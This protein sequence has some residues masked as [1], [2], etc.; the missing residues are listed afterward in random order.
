MHRKNLVWD[1]LKYF[2]VLCRTKR[3][4]STAS[5]LK[6]SR[7]TVS[8]RIK[9]LE[10]CLGVRLF[11]HYEHG[12]VPTKAGKELL[13][14][15]ES[16][17]GLISNFYHESNLYF[18]NKS[19]IKIGLNEGI[20]EH[21]LA[22]EIAKYAKEKNQTIKLISLP[23]NNNVITK[24]VDISIT[25]QKPKSDLIINRLLTKYNL[26]IYASK[27]FINENR[28]IIGKNL[29]NLPWVGYI[30]DLVY[31]EALMYHL[32]LPEKIDFIF[33]STSLNAQEQAVTAGLGMA[34]LPCYIG[35]RNKKIEKV[36]PDIVFKRKY[37][38]STRKDIINSKELKKAW[39][40]IINICKKNEDLFS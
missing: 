18:L 8:N 33:Q 5:Q 37:W 21:F 2:I 34:I 40:H 24:E 30:Q 13:K 3:I 16:I 15:S 26:S 32:E 22:Y 14:T 1:D 36:F 39:D 20:S 4:S 23:R 19:I 9:S 29:K 27:D 35:N 7:A 28:N 12:F 6:I 17:E 25:I 11:D 10:D 38:I 31:S